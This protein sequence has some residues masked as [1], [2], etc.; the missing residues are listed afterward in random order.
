MVRVL[1]GMLFLEVYLGDTLLVAAAE[2][3]LGAILLAAA[4][5]SHLRAILEAI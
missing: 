5:E 1:N 2:A 4:V 3:H